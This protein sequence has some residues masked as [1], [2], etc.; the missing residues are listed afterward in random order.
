MEIADFAL[1]MIYSRFLAVKNSSL[2]GILLSRIRNAR[3]APLKRT[4]FLIGQQAYAPLC[5]TERHGAIAQTVG[6]GQEKKPHNVTSII[7]M[8]ARS[9]NLMFESK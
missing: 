6:T 4:D 8:T 7:M 2:S 5:A 3:D 1:A 9:D